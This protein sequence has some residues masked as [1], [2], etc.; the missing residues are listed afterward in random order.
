[1]KKFKLIII[2]ACLLIAALALAACGGE[3]GGPAGAQEPIQEGET[4]RDFTI[5]LRD[6]G[7]FTLSEHSG[8]VVLVNFWA[9]WC[10]G[11]IQEMPAFELLQEAYGEEL[12]ILAIGCDQ[13][14][15]EAEAFLAEQDFTFPIALDP[16]RR[17][18]ELYPSDGLPYTLVIDKRGRV[19]HIVLSSGEPEEVFAHYQ[20]LIDPLLAE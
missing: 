3:A 16:E 8:Q 18:V 14:Q 19:A 7:S 1:M 9:T 17:L 13:D 2:L 15:A 4:A 5:E 12:A 20:E 6:G 10:S 11:C